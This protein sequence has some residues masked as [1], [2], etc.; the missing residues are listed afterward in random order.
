MTDMKL[1]LSGY[2][3]RI[4]PPSTFKWLNKPSSLAM[5]QY[6]QPK[7]T[8]ASLP[9]GSAHKPAEFAATASVDITRT[10]TAMA[11]AALT[12]DHLSNGRMILGLG[13]SR[14]L[15]LVRRHFHYMARTGIYSVIR[16]GAAREEPVANDGEHPHCTWDLG[17][18]Q[19][20][21]PI[22][23]STLTYR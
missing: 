1:G 19:P 2:W 5:I 14:S 16:Q 3:A 21:K 23:S 9:L 10:P 4:R 20:L 7:P 8:A 18:G 11:M 17:F 12:M 6:G 13:V 15:R 22:P